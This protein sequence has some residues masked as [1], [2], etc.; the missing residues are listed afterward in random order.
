MGLHA[1]T[2]NEYV[3]VVFSMAQRANAWK[4]ARPARIN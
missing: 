2:R 1:H 3:A 4:T